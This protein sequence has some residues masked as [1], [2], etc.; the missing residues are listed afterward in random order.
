MPVARNMKAVRE[1]GMLD[2]R[3]REGGRVRTDWREED[4]KTGYLGLKG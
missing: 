1:I 3:P 4:N 2:K